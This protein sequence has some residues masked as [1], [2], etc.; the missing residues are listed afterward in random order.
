MRRIASEAE[1]EKY[2]R[3]MI[4]GDGG[5]SLVV[6]AREECVALEKRAEE[7]KRTISHCSVCALYRVHCGAKKHCNQSI[8]L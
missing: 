6:E 4:S 8:S 5:V 7:A 1:E 3:R 2:F